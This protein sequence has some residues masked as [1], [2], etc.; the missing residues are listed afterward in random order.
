MLR[1]NPNLYQQRFNSVPSTHIKKQT[2]FQRG[3]DYSKNIFKNF[4]T[5]IEKNLKNNIIEKEVTKDM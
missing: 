4:N 3:I 2:E 1:N 5:Y